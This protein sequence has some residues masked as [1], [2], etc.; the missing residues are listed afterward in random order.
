MS[1]KDSF[2]KNSLISI[3]GFGVLVASSF[4]FNAFAGRK[5]GVN[6]WGIFNSLFFLLYAFTFPINS[7]QLAVTKYDESKALSRKKMFH[8]LASTLFVY[9][10]IIAII[11][12]LL[13]PFLKNIL[14]LPHLVYPVIGGFIL[15]FWIVLAGVRG[16]YQGNMDFK[17]YGLSLGLEG[18]LRM[19]FGV[20]F[21]FLGMGIGGALG[22]SL[23]SGFFAVIYLVFS[24]RKT[25][26]RDFFQLKIDK[27][28]TGEFLKALAVLLPFGLILVLDTTLVQHII[29]GDEAGYVNACALF[30]KNLIIMSMVF[31]NVVFSYS[32][33]KDSSYLFWGIVIT[34]ITIALAAVFMFPL[35]EWVIHLLLGEDFLPAASYLPMYIIM[36][37]P[38]GVMLHIFNYSIARNIK[39]IKI[40]SWVILAAVTI[41]LSLVLQK[42]DIAHFLWV[43]LVIFS[44]SDVILLLFLLPFLKNEQKA[45]D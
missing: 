37:L 7:L 36:M 20:L 23:A 43:G 38:L 17:S 14:N 10:A 32:L 30:G 8:K 18:L 28:I 39:S 35:G 29:G 25:F 27:D 12:L 13:M 40:T 44:V 21:I 4:A 24:E 42:H 22:A 9:A 15:A 1:K 19:G 6:N 41:I 45:I 2:A 5:L 31:A 26:F 16:V 3:I 11:F 33:K 34:S